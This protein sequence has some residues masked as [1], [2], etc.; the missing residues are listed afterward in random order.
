MSD[1]SA[2]G[3]RPNIF[4]VPLGLFG[5]GHVA[6]RLYEFEGAPFDV[7]ARVIF[8]IAGFVFA[9]VLLAYLVQIVARK[10]DLKRDLADTQMMNYSPALGMVLVLAGAAL[11]PYEASTGAFL[12]LLGAFTGLFFSVL[13]VRQWLTQAITPEQI[14]TAW[15]FPVAGNLVAA[16]ALSNLKLELL[17]LLFGGLGVVGWLMLLPI[18]FRRLILA[19]ELT[20]VLLPSLFIMIAPQGLV[21]SAL[22][23]LLPSEVAL[24]VAALVLGFGLFLL[25]TLVSLR[26]HFEKSPYSIAWWAYTFPTAALAAGSLDLAAKMDAAGLIVLAEV[27][28][29]L[30]LALTAGVGLIALLNLRKEKRPPME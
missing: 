18:I 25:I 14:S 2:S 30:N 27:L 22:L 11:R 5:A 26:G 10:I 15:F 23:R 24:P 1:A 20:P 4:T 7:A 6:G 29:S 28:A 13:V 8:F 9:G 3:L 12:I 16:T 17:A 19:K 21:M